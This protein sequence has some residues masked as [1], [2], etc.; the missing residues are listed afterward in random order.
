[1]SGGPGLSVVTAPASPD[2]PPFLTN[3]I[4]VR[5]PGLAAA[6]QTPRASDVPEIPHS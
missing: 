5:Q 1:M 4:Q 3:G 2:H 6:L